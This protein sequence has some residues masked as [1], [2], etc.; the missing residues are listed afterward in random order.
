MSMYASSGLRVFGPLGPGRT[1]SRSAPIEMYS[2]EVC[3]K[4]RSHHC[5]RRRPNEIVMETA[6]VFGGKGEEVGL[7]RHEHFFERKEV[8]LTC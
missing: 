2:L 7:Y 6:F 4:H 8:S 5:G 1:L 3:S